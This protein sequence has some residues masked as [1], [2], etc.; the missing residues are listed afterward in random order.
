M[1][2]HM[3]A[4]EDRF[5]P[6]PNHKRRQELNPNARR[7]PPCWISRDEKALTP[8]GRAHDGAGGNGRGAHHIKRGL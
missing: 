7:L 1:Y 5:A 3:R 4:L 2:D 8:G 6:E